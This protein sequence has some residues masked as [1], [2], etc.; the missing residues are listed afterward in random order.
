MSLL[1]E[2]VLSLLLLLLLQLLA[3]RC[4]LLREVWPLL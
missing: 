2:V 3:R 1:M 4:A